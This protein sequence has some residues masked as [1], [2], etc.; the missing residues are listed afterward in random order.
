MNV[1]TGHDHLD[2]YQ[3]PHHPRSAW[4]TSPSLRRKRVAGAMQ[5]DPPSKEAVA[6]G[7]MLAS[8][9]DI[10]PLLVTCMVGRREHNVTLAAL[11]ATCEDARAAVK[12]AQA[13]WRKALTDLRD[14]VVDKTAALR[15]AHSVPVAEREL[16]ERAL[17]RVTLKMN[18]MLRDA[19]GHSFVK[20]YGMQAAMCS[21]YSPK[22]VSCMHS[23]TCVLCNVPITPSDNRSRGGF[24]GMVSAMGDSTGWSGRY[25]FAHARCVHEQ[26]ATIS[27]GVPL[28]NEKSITHRW[29]SW[30]P[31][32]AFAAMCAYCPATEIKPS[33]Y[34]AHVNNGRETGPAGSRVPEVDPQVNPAH[35]WAATPLSLWVSPMKDVVEWRDTAMGALEVR[36]NDMEAI[37]QRAEEMQRKMQRK[38]ERRAIVMQQ[39]EREAECARRGDVR[40]VL[41]KLHVQNKAPWATLEQLEELHPMALERVGIGG[42]VQEHGRAADLELIGESTALLSRFVMATATQRIS[43]P[44]LNFVLNQ[45]ELWGPKNGL[46]S[47][48]RSLRNQRAVDFVHMLNAFGP[49]NYKFKRIRLAPDRSVWTM[50]VTANWH[51]KSVRA[52]YKLP[53]NALVA[54][55]AVLEEYHPE[56]DMPSFADDAEPKAALK[57]MIDTALG[58]NVVLK[59]RRYL[60]H[61]GREVAYELL[62]MQYMLLAH[63]RNL[64]DV[65]GVDPQVPGFGVPWPGW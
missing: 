23:R 65:K 35:P 2:V 7:N 58:T 38:R 13:E 52:A 40:R 26:C 61:P 36:S 30:V 60:W 57:F 43:A 34:V 5:P 17:A 14:Q 27:Y 50:L 51:G 12:N 20:D 41:G 53:R 21:L 19:F 39:R 49:N 59:G 4:A 3:V 47:A 6:V 33:A 10:W 37:V 55:R 18:H 24:F 63:M 22:V 15:A 45:A 29:R 46:D 8:C 28:H 48:A 9:S 16:K 42:Y 31:G 44:T 56:A 62:G 1:E 11:Y 25:T 64:D 54:A 32:D